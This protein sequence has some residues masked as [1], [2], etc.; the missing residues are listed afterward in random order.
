MSIDV[1]GRIPYRLALAGGWIDQPFISRLNPEPPGS[2]VVVSLRPTHWYMERSGM[3]TGTRR[4]ARA[5][6]G[7][8]IPGGDPAAQVRTLYEAENRNLPDPSGSQDMVGLIYGGVSR[9]DYDARVGGGVFP[10]HIESCR[11][12]E[13]ARW[14]ERVLHLLP[15][16]P[17]PEGYHPLEE[18]NPDP[19]WVARLGRT[20]RACYDA[21]RARDAAALGASMNACMECWERL[22]PGT[23]RHPT[24]RIDLKAILGHYQARSLGAMFSG[25]G[26]GYLAIVSEDPV[27]GAARV[28]VR[29][30]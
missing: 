20:G 22:L 30:S 14:L 25:C 26:G 24:I 29:E 5:L 23:I 18:M 4:V 6:W 15:V 21:I 1:L 16:G 17:R 11:D 2:M 3:A 8:A 13:V 9:L 28:S 12:R 7:D 10:A 19:A 27:P